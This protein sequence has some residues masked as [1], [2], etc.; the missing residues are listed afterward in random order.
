MVKIVCACKR[1]WGGG[2]RDLREG[3]K[4]SKIPGW[5][6]V[7]NVRQKR[8]SLPTPPVLPPLFRRF[9][10]DRTER[11]ATRDRADCLRHSLPFLL[12]V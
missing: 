5:L 8:I 12:G 6:A 9:G 7:H 10:H 3:S 1:E 2:E 11:G 4:E